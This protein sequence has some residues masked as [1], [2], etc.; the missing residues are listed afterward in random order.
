ME[1]ESGIT[2]GEI[3]HLIKKRVWWILGISVIVAIIAALAVGLV[4]NRGKNDYTLTFIVDFPG[5]ENNEYPD[6]TSFNYEEIVYSDQLEAAKASNE[7]FSEIDTAKMAAG[8]ITIVAETREVTSGTTT[9]TEKTGSYTITVSSAYFTDEDQATAFLR[10]VLDQTIARVNEIAAGMDF[11]ANLSA[12]TA[13]STYDAQLTALRDQ[14]T[15]L[16]ARYDEL[17][18]TG[19]YDSFTYDGRSLS[20]LRAEATRGIETR[21]S[22]L[23]TDLAN[24]HYLLDQSLVETVLVDIRFLQ[25]EKEQNEQSI[26]ALHKA[27]AEFLA[28]INVSG[29]GDGSSGSGSDNGNNG[30]TQIIESLASFTSRIATL[31]ESNAKIDFQITELYESI[32]YTNENGVWEAPAETITPDDDDDKK[33]KEAVEELRNTISEKNTTTAKN[34]IVALY[35]AESEIV[36]RQSGV[37]VIDNGTNVIL[38]TVAGFIV[39]FLLA[40]IIFCAADYPAYKK[41]RDAKAAEETALPAEA[42]AEAA[43]AEDKK[44]EE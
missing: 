28:Q 8:D 5:V 31:Q 20:T 33:F 32:G 41:A 4:F 42:L 16:L 13:A 1:E 14:Q 24:N 29:S 3:L 38:V 36:Y 39:A 21:L 6:G 30:S 2:F 10:A 44:D 22:A 11:T 15:F 34:A 9:T 43:A 27:C 19:K 35:D 18:A 40:C 7:S 37:A 23:E 25:R 26:A 12:Y 17:I